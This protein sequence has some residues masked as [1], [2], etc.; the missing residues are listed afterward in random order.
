MKL[1]ELTPMLYT[2]DLQGSVEFYVARLGF[3]CKAMNED[4]GWACVQRDKGSVMFAL[5]NPHLP[6]DKPA[7]TGSLYFNV[8][9]VDAMWRQMQDKVRFCYPIENFEYGMREFAIYD[10]NGY[11]LQFG[12]DISE[13]RT[14]DSV[15]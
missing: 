1:Q 6:F 5:P 3:Q 11:L 14:D 8:D 15:S 7:F 9:D 2:E 10:N 12:Q 13:S 4:W